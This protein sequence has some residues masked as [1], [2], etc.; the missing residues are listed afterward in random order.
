LPS[1]KAAR[2]TQRESEVFG[3]LARGLSNQEIASEL[4][5]ALTTVKRHVQ[6]LFSKLDINSRTQAALLFSHYHR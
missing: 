4:D 1:L 6:N 5:I 3:A 2:L